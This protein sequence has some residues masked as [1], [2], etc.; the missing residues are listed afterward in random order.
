M[1]KKA[2]KKTTTTKRVTAKKTVAK[3]PVKVEQYVQNPEF[4]DEH[5]VFSHVMY[6]LFLVAAAIAAYFTFGMFTSEYT[7]GGEFFPV[8]ALV[9]LGWAFLFKVFAH[10]IHPPHY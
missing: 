5:R 10:R 7:S 6:L 3:K 1:P 4:S 2:T 8:K 9:L